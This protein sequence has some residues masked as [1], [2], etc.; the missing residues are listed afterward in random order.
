[1]VRTQ[2]LFVQ[3]L[4]KDTFE[5]ILWLKTLSKV[6]F[7]STWTKSGYVLT[8]FF[9]PVPQISTLYVIVNFYEWSG[10]FERS[11][12]TSPKT[13]S[14]V[15]F[16]QRVVMVRTQ[17]LFVQML[18]KDTFESILWLQPKTLSKVSFRSSW[19]KSG[20]VL[21]TYYRPVPTTTQQS[22]GAGARSAPRSA[23]APP[24]PTTS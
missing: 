20:C 8:T 13:L 10:P 24:L 1:M 9:R 23:A 21:T 12:W 22:A 2:P 7:G 14:K 5:S 6:S 19:T 15:S 3:V 18:P 16:E 17:P 11:T 4:P